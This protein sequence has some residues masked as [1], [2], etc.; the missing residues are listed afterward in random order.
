MESP[1]AVNGSQIRRIRRLI[2]C[3][4]FSLT[5]TSAYSQSSVWEIRSKTGRLF[6]GGTIHVLRPSDYPLPREYDKAFAEADII[7]FETDLGQ[8]QQADT[9]AR[10]MEEGFYKEGDIADRLNQ[11]TLEQLQD[12]LKRYGLPFEAVAKMKPGLL[13]ATLS[14]LQLQDRGFAPEGVD[15]HFYR[16]AGEA[17]KERGYLESVDRQIRLITEMGAGEEDAFIR[18]SLDDLNNSEENLSALIDDWKNGTAGSMNRSL[19]EMKDSFPGIYSA[20][21]DDRNRKW[22]P[23][24]EDYLATDAVEFVLFGALHLYGDDGLLELLKEKGYKAKQL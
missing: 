18:Y 6:L 4:L 17:G 13:T 14:M 5:M 22:L 24:M 15:Q 12:A 20:L 9:A 8:L 21:I 10:I 23:L 11:E 7:V 16:K 3:L 1:H 19:E 2:L